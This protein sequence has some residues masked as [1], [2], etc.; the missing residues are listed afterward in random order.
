M[1]VCMYAC[2]HVCM[3]ACMHTCMYACMHANVL[4]LRIYVC[5]YVC[6]CDVAQIGLKMSELQLLTYWTTYLYCRANKSVSYAAPAYYA[7]WAS[8]RGET[9]PILG[10]RLL[11]CRLFFYFLSLSLLAYVCLDL[12]VHECMHV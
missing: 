4:I 7:H 9:G 5:M 11:P 2:M 8:K 6:G 10:G 1:H 3:Y 12:R